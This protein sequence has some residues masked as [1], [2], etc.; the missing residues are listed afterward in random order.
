MSESKLLDSSNGFVSSR[1]SH[2]TSARETIFWMSHRTKIR[3]WV[4]WARIM[5]KMGNWHVGIREGGAG[6]R[7]VGTKRS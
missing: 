6:H 3:L 4:V 1:V 7:M 5:G 2:F